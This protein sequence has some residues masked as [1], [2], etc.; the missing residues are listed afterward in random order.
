MFVKAVIKNQKIPFEITGEPPY[1][2]TNMAH[3]RRGIKAL[4]EGKGVEHDLLTC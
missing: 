3:L 4:D 1:T 2:A